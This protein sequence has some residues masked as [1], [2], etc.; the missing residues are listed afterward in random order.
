MLA[1]PWTIVLAA[2]SGRRL[3]RITGGIPKQFWSPPGG[4]TLLEQ[5]LR[6]MAPL[7]PVPATFSGASVE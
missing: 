3:A 6:R 5:T 7:A 1:V 4:T 2:G